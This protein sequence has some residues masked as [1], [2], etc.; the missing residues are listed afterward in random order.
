VKTPKLYLA[1]S[2]LLCALLG[3]RSVSD[4]GRSP[5]VGAIW[6]TVVASELRRG[7]LNAGRS[8][9][10]FFWRNREREVDFVI[11]RAGRFVLVEAKWTELPDARDAANLR[12]VAAQL[13]KGSVQ[14]LAVVCR[15]AHAYPLGA[16]VEAV[17]L[18][19]VGRLLD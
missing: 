15:C 4:L 16:D 11:H 17:P 8:G 14:R 13:P 2:G 5:L 18:D 10:L 19:E 7:L 9:E 1:D 6:E 3:V 12:W